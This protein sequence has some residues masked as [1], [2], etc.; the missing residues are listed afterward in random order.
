[1]IDA[2]AGLFAKIHRLKRD[3]FLLSYTSVD[4]RWFLGLQDW[5]SLRLRP[6]GGPG[7]NRITINFQ[8]SGSVSTKETRASPALR[9]RKRSTGLY[10]LVGSM[11]CAR[12]WMKLVTRFASRHANR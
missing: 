2:S 8:N 7:L 9:G 11:A 6:T 4:K 10:V 1:M 5:F 12:A 3:R